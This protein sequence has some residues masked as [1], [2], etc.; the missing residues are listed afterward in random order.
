[1]RGGRGGDQ[2]PEEQLRTGVGTNVEE[3]HGISYDLSTLTFDR[4]HLVSAKTDTQ[5][6][7][8]SHVLQDASYPEASFFCGGRL[9]Q[10]SP[11]VQR[12]QTEQQHVA[13]GHTCVHCNWDKAPDSFCG[14]ALEETAA[15]TH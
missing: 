14:T 6:D 3:H 2:G 7:K 5:N 8:G 15:I 12:C 1:M 10:V 9:I 13:V 11:E 4:V